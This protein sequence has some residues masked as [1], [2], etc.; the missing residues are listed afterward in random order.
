M[1]VLKHIECL[2]HNRH[3]SKFRDSSSEQN[4][5]SATPHGADI[6]FREDTQKGNK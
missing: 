1:F 4:R 3:C 6:L 2:I 5:Q